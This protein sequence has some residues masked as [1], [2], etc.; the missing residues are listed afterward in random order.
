MSKRQKEKAAVRRAKA[1]AA[2][3]RAELK[4]LRM[5]AS[6]VRLVTDLIRNKP[7]EEALNILTFTPKS[8]ARPVAKL[9]RSAVA[10][11]DA[12]GFDVDALVISQALVGEA[13]QMKRFR[14]RAMGRANRILKRSC[15]VTLELN[16]RE[17]IKALAAKPP[18]AE[19]APATASAAPAKTEKKTKKASDKP[20]AKA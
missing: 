7:V 11:A 6:K 2:A 1:K 17:A 16:T 13:T 5:A 3:P 18:K 9:L 8:A 20:K 19:R 12:K 14:P 15:H 10:N 4:L